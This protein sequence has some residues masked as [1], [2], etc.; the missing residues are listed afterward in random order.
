MLKHFTKLT[1]LVVA[2]LCAASVASGGT[3]VLREGSL[4]SSPWSFGDEVGGQMLAVSWTQPFI[5]TNWSIQAN[6]IERPEEED[7]T[8]RFELRSGALDGAVMG[9]FTGTLAADTAAHDYL[10]LQ[11][12]QP[13]VQATLQPGTYYLIASATD[14]ANWY[15]SDSALNWSTD[16]P[17]AVQMGPE[18]TFDGGQWFDQGLEGPGLGFQ[19]QGDVT[20]DGAV[21][22]PAG[23][24]LIGGGLL[25]IGALLRRR[26]RASA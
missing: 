10:V 3:V 5:L 7:P 13:G 8:V 16:Y 17:G 22:E 1:V 25:L 9:I 18:F 6:K 11:H 26:R 20:A 14:Y 19:V 15:G 24:T 23:F 21:P 12:N 4:D 2:C